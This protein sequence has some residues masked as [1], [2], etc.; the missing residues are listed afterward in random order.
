MQGLGPNV[1][2]DGFKE[3]KGSLRTSGSS[4]NIDALLYSRF[5]QIDH[6]FNENLRE[7]GL[8]EHDFIV[9][10]IRD[11]IN[12][13]P[14]SLPSSALLPTVSEPLIASKSV[15]EWGDN[16]RRVLRRNIVSK[17]RSELATGKST[18]DTIR[19]I[20]GRPIKWLQKRIIQASLGK[21][22]NALSGLESLRSQM[23]SAN[24]SIASTPPLLRAFIGILLLMVTPLVFAVINIVLVGKILLSTL[25]EILRLIGAVFLISIV[26]VPL[27]L[28]FRP[29]TS[30]SQ[31]A[32]LFIVLRL[33]LRKNR[34]RTTKHLW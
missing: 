24:E 9:D 10:Q 31:D 6:E 14:Y 19:K 7:L 21:T 34:I 28:Y 33:D 18:E 5:Y 30:V 23:M 11:S 20:K 2:G 26:G 25:K 27:Y 3:N 4:E 32:S 17:V 12:E 16:I 15:R 29:N 1:T 22:S 13:I 8:L